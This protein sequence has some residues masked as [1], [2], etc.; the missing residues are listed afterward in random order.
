MIDRLETVQAFVAVCDAKGFAA[1]A[2]KLGLSAPAVTRLVASLEDRIGVRLLQRTTRSVKQTDA[3]ARFL[4]HARR[5]LAEVDEAERSAQ[6]E[7]AE[8]GGRLVVSAPLL[9]GR[10]HVA[11]VLSRFLDLYPLVRAELE[12]SDRFVHLV[13]DGID[14]AI[15]IG[16]LAELGADRRSE[17]VKPDGCWWQARAT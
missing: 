17:S 3:G 10:M 13:E 4:E 5:I 6:S 12:L 9:F 7:R 15:R 8:P 14:V 11:P 2:R 16:E 1:A